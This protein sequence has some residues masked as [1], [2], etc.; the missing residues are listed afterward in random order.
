MSSSLLLQSA[1][2]ELLPH[3]SIA[4]AAASLPPLLRRLTVKLL[5]SPYQDD[6]LPHGACTHLRP[7]AMVHVK[8][9]DR[10]P[11]DVVVVDG[12]QRGARNIVED[13]VAA[14]RAAVCVVARRPAGRGTPRHTMMRVG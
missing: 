12:C 1:V 14:P 6:S 11:A 9:N 10:D 4:A 7:V 5:E 3:S 2:R 13:A 8:V